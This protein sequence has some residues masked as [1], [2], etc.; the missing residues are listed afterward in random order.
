MREVRGRVVSWVGRRSFE[1]VRKS[2]RGWGC[3]SNVVLCAYVGSSRAKSFVTR[4]LAREGF[5]TMARLLSSGL[6]PRSKAQSE[7]RVRQQESSPPSMERGEGCCKGK[8]GDP[9][10]L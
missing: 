8:Q 6:G 3:A 5:F 7:W 10:L 4:A 9:P 1:G 2:V